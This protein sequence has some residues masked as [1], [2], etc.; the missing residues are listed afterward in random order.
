VEAGY[1]QNTQ[2]FE[3]PD[4]EGGITNVEE[5]RKDW[6]VD[7]SWVRSLGGRWALGVVGEIGSSTFLNQDLRWSVKPGVEFNFFPYA[8]SSRRSLTLQYLLGPTHLDYT[9]ETIFG[10]T[11]ETRAQQS[12]TASVGLV[13]PW[14]R[15]NTSLTGAQYLHDP[16]KYNV[17]ISGNVNIRLFRGFSIRLSGNYAWLRDQL[18]ISAQGATEEQILLQ[19]RQ[20]ETSFRYF[21]SFGIEYRFGSIFN[22]VVNPRFGGGRSGMMFF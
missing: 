3:Y 19:Q 11:E 5:T 14:G 16:E 2:K 7:A 15:W 13:Q 20:L 18:F 21:T 10:R 4:G 9:H 1:S 8:E 6:N 12:L 17:S 22:N